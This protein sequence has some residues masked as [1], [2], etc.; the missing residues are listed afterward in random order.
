MSD[1]QDILDRAYMILRDRGICRH[2]FAVDKDGNP[3]PT[4]DS[5]AV[6][7]CGLGATCRAWYEVGGSDDD[8][9]EAQWAVTSALHDHLGEEVGYPVWH[10]EVATNDDILGLFEALASPTVCA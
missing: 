8:Y 9:Y 10:D 2:S 6:K 3:V 7:F 4:G 1:K 5:S